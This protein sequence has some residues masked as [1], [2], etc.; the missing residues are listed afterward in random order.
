MSVHLSVKTTQEIRKSQK[1]HIFMDTVF[2]TT[3]FIEITN[4]AF[5]VVGTDGIRV[6]FR[7]L[8]N[9][10]YKL[11]CTFDKS[12]NTIEFKFSQDIINMYINDISMC[13]DRQTILLLMDPKIR[14]KITTSANVIINRNLKRYENIK[15][16]KG[17]SFGNLPIGCFVLGLDEITVPVITPTYGFQI[18]QAVTK[19]IKECWKSTNNLVHIY[20]GDKFDIG[21]VDN[22]IIITYNKTDVI[23]ITDTEHTKI[24]VEHYTKIKDAMQEMFDAYKATIPKI[25]DIQQ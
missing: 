10:I 5:D 2:M 11:I 15:F 19:W 13:A 4:K 7:E 12:I 16:K 1:I 22:I 9:S 17:E 18:S 20:Y 21:C 6:K 25:I 14:E 24:L 3:I 8:K 23:V